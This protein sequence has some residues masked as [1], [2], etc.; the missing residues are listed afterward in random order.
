VTDIYEG[1][2]VRDSATGA[3]VVVGKS[4]GP[5]S[6]TELGYAESTANFST[7]STSAVDVTSLTKT[8]M[9]GSRPIKCIHGCYRQTINA[10]AGLSQASIQEGATV[11]NARQV[12]SQQA[13]AGVDVEGSGGTTIARLGDAKQPSAGSH[14]YKVTLLVGNA[15]HTGQLLAAATTP[16]Y[17][18]IEEC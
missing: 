4:G 16:S 17:L 13:A 10:D 18:Q 9:V 1:G 5:P 8:V 12:Q 7:S 15:A 3:L 6:G 11:L 14:T 2:F